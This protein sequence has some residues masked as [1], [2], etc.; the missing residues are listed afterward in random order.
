MNI[1][2]TYNQVGGIF[3]VTVADSTLF[4]SPGPTTYSQLAVTSASKLSQEQLL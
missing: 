3:S 1:V 2:G 4:N